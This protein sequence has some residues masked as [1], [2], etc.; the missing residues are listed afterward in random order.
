MKIGAE[1]RKAP[2]LQGSRGRTR[3]GPRCPVLRANAATLARRLLG[4]LLGCAQSNLT[5]LFWW[6]GGD[7]CCDLARRIYF[8]GGAF[9]HVRAPSDLRQGV[10]LVVEGILGGRKKY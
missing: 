2:R 6:L 10:M 4:W 5:L 3:E 9:P 1:T 8:S 7:R